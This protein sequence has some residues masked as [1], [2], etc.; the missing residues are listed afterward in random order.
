MPSLDGAPPDHPTS[1]GLRHRTDGE[2]ARAPVG[3]RE[4]DSLGIASDPGALGSL[5]KT[6]FKYA[7]RSPILKILFSKVAKT[8]NAGHFC[9]F[10]FDH[11]S[12]PCF[13]ILRCFHG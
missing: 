6:Q 11:S 1:V 12:A 2:A 10:G 13:A 9:T 3:G 4:K 8:K 5:Q 7:K